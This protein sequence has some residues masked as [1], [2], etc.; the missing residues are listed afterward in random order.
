MAKANKITSDKPPIVKT[1]KGGV[2]V[3]KGKKFSAANQPSKEK[4]K[5]GWARRNALK[6]IL[7]ISVNRMFEGTKKNYTQLAAAF[8]GIPVK[9]VSLRMV[10]E[11]RQIEKAVLQGDTSAFE[12]VYNRAYG[13]T[14]PEGEA[15][16]SVTIIIK[17]KK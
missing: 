11:Y 9:E 5:A 8:L 2:P 13:R 16:S 4:K 10:M 1:G 14:K 15:P 3:P 12:A 7:N 6:D 17:G